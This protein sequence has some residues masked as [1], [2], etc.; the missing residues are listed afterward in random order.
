MATNIAEAT[1]VVNSSRG[2]NGGCQWQGHDAVKT[3]PSRFEWVWKE[4]KRFKS[5]REWTLAAELEPER[6]AKYLRGFKKGRS[7][8][9]A[10]DAIEALAR[11]ARVSPGWLAFGEGD[12]D[13]TMNALQRLTEEIAALRAA[14]TPGRHRKSA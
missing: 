9:I 3:V 1:I 4:A 10:L 8:S 2:D 12:P 14:T 5:Q 13:G 11:V 6:V 7:P